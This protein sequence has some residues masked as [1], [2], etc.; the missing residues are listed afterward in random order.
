MQYKL[1]LWKKGVPISPP[2]PPSSS[3]VFNSH[4]SKVVD[5]EQ[6]LFLLRDS[7]GKRTREQ[8]SVLIARGT[9]T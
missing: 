7:R 5:Y 9:E 1:V 8:A 4:F 6:S 2:P 3:V